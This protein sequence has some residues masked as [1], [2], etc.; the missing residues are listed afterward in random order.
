MPELSPHQAVNDFVRRGAELVELRG[1][2][3]A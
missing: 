2:A 3:D 1:D